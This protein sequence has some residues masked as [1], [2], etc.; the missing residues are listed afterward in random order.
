[1]KD[2]Y[3]R[4]IEYLRIS[5]TKQ[6]NMKCLYCQP[7]S[8][9]C[10]SINCESLSPEDFH[11][12]VSIMAGLGIRKV[13]LTGG[14]PLVR[15]DIVE[16]IRNISGI[17]G[18]ID[19]SMTTN[20]IKLADMAEEL[21][22]AGLMRVNISLDS[23]QPKKFQEI[24]GS[25]RFTDVTNGIRKAF[26]TGLWPV[27][28]NTVLIRG[29]N[30]NEIDDFIEFARDLP[31][32]VRFIELMPFGKFGED[33]RH[34]IIYGSKIVAARPQL[35][36]IDHTDPS[37]PSD[38]YRIEGY[39][40]RIGFISPISH[41]FCGNCNRIRLTCDG[42]LKPCLGSNA[43]IDLL[44]AL[45]SGGPEL[46][47]LITTAIYQKPAGHNFYCGP[48]SDRNMNEIGG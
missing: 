18:I 41:K 36:H 11:R 39:K 12:I 22:A 6:C 30:D 19:I 21:K 9:D 26:E 7:E 13:R 14:E 8:S 38:Y 45:Q 27:R 24:T 47:E 20:G 5:V 4:E 37:L 15:S 40:G 16:I 1:M 48:R 23:L 43:E 32:D 17:N 3:G 31:V 44:Q 2:S 10:S 35:I 42:K 33:N 28:I 46:E 29:I 25:S 34:R